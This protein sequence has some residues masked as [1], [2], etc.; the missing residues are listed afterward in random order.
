MLVHE[1]RYAVTARVQ[2]YLVAKSWDTEYVGEC[3]CALRA[4]DLYKSVEDECRPGGRLDVYRPCI[5]GL[6][7]YIKFT[8]GEDGD[9]YVLTFCRNGESH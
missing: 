8:I 2:R 5:G 7:L 4:G 6:R 9:L 3:L 1:G